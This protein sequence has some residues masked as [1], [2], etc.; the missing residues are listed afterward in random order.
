MDYNEVDTGVIDLLNKLSLFI[1]FRQNLKMWLHYM[2]IK[3]TWPGL[4]H[5]LQL[6]ET[7]ME[8]AMP[9]RMKRFI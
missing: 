9:V 2:E 6:L 4:V 8:M 5:R 7:S 1:N 3:R